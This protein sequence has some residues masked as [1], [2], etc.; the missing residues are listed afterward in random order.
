MYDKEE[1]DDQCKGVTAMKFFK[2]GRNARIYCK[3]I[4]T[5]E[6]LYVVICCEYLPKK[7]QQELRQAERNIIRR[8]ANY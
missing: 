8:V 4:I 5:D 3:E 6:G 1:I 2:G 7:K